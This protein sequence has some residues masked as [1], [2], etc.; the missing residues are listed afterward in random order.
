MNLHFP[1]IVSTSRSFRRCRPIYAAFVGESLSTTTRPM[2]RSTIRFCGRTPGACKWTFWAFGG[3]FRRRRTTCTRATCMT[4]E[5]PTPS[6]IHRSR[7][8]LRRSCGSFGTARSPFGTTF[9]FRSSLKTLW[10]RLKGRG[11]VGSTTMSGRCSSKPC[12]ISSKGK[13][14]YS[15]NALELAYTE[16]SFLSADACCRE[17]SLD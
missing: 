12:T 8:R 4:I 1:S 16:S 2:I 11:K 3:A 13:T 5:C 7:W 10:K 15:P 6:L 9:S 17:A 14:F